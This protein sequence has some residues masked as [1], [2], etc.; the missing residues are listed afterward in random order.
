M[1]SYKVFAVLAGGVAA[2]SVSPAA[3]RAQDTVTTT[4]PI[5]VKQTPAK[6]VWMKATVVHADAVSLIVRERDNQMAIHTFSLSDEAKAKMQGIIDAG[7]YQN[8]D[9]IRVL[10][11]PGSQTAI[12]FKGRPSKGV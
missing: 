1:K 6:A 11:M 4:A 2:L 7:G 8:G 5:V 3:I 10:W 9:S 12:K